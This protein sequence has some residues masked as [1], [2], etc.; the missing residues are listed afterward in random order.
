MSDS[1]ADQLGALA[2]ALNAPPASDPFAPVLLV[3]FGPL[4]FSAPNR[5]GGIHA[6]PGEAIQVDASAHNDGEYA[7]TSCDAD[8]VTVSP[9]VVD[10][11]AG[12]APAATIHWLPEEA[13]P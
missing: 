10:E 13:T 9:Y 4:L 5:I 7:V 3:P 1:P 12:M 6:P 2:E 11:P 8:G